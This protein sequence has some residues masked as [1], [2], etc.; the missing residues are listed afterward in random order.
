MIQFPIGSG[1]EE[2]ARKSD[3]FGPPHGRSEA[4]L[5][6]PHCEE[7]GATDNI[8][9]VGIG[10]RLFVCSR[11]L[12]ETAEELWSY[13]SLAVCRRVDGV[14]ALKE[15]S[16]RGKDPCAAFDVKGTRFEIVPKRRSQMACGILDS[17]RYHRLLTDASNSP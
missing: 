7:E 2:D 12:E 3:H 13:R 9:R 8:G 15:R 14:E 17:A 6:G 5:T 16:D 4:I 10:Q 1:S 11:E